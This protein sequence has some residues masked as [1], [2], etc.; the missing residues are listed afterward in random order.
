MAVGD[1]YQMTITTQYVTG[2]VQMNNVFHFRQKGGFLSAINLIGEWR[3]GCEAEH[4]ACLS[5]QIHIIKYSARTLVPF[6]SDFYEATF[7][8]AGTDGLTPLPPLVAAIITWRTG[9]AGRRKRGRSYIGGLD[10][11][12]HGGNGTLSPT[13]VSTRITPFANKV[14]SVFGSGGTNPNAEIGIWSRLNAGPDPPF[15][16]AGFQVMTSYTV[17]TR[18]GSMG[19]RRLGRGL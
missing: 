17:Q 18:M 11:N 9:L 4:R 10:R 13:Y 1:I 6:N 12:E 3:V 15:D 8:L 5:S 16:P 19:T 7:A 2:G 14:Y